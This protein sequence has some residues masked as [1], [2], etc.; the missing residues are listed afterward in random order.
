MDL[1]CRFRA[2]P[3]SRQSSSSDRSRR[4]ELVKRVRRAAEVSRGLSSG[5][6]AV[7]F[8]PAKVRLQPNGEPAQRLVTRSI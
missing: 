5:E 6:P 1:S 3:R 7:G 8:D 2:P 4:R